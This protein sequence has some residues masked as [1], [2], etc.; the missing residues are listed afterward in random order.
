MTGCAHD[1]APTVLTQTEVVGCL[2]PEPA[3]L[4]CLVP[5]V[6]AQEPTQGDDAEL[7]VRQRMALEQCRGNMRQLREYFAQCQSDSAASTPG[8]L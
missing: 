2:P 5:R 4:E 3:L 8:W 7:L 1:A 6:T